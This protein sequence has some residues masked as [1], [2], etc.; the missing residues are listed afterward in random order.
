MEIKQIAVI[1]TMP[2]DS[3]LI[4]AAIWTYPPNAV[5]GP[6]QFRIPIEEVFFF[7]IQ[8]YTTGLVYCIFTKPLVRRMYLQSCQKKQLRDV[9]AMAM[10]GCIGI[11]I[12]CL[13]FGGRAIYLGLILVWGCPIL[14]FQWYVCSLSGGRCLPFRMLSYPF[15]TARPLKLCLPTMHLWV[16]DTRVMRAGTWMIESGTKMNYQCYGLEVEYD[17]HVNSRPV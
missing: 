5:I 9:I 16:A 13:F 7:V 15:I 2:W 14:L 12:A 1:T 4:R 8:T 11:G 3:Y 17:I 10:L 6:T